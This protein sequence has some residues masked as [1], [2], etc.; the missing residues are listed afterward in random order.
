MT[1]GWEKTLMVLTVAGVAAAAQ[2]QAPTAEVPPSASAQ[3]KAAALGL[4]GAHEVAAFTTAPPCFTSGSPAGSVED[5]KGYTFLKICISERG[6]ITYFESPAGK[7]HLRGREGYAVCSGVNDSTV[8]GFDAGMAES[9][10]GPPTVSQ[11][12]GG[13]MLP[14]TIERDSLDG[15][16][17]LTQTFTINSGARELQVKVSVKNLSAVAITPRLARYFDGDIDDTASDDRYDRTTASVWG[18]PYVTGIANGLMLT[19]TTTLPVSEGVTQ[20]SP[21]KFSDWNPFGSGAQS[22][23]RCIGTAGLSVPTP[24]GDY[25]GRALAHLGTINPGET[26]TVT[27]RYRRF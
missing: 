15:V 7:V 10:W 12:N 27:Y 22:A 1:R 11:P 19:Q 24:A 17:R 5:P 21:E 26:R 8:Y 23:R 14:L 4:L 20:I 13:D 3:K 16:V 18:T 6:N 2:A 25:V 9:G